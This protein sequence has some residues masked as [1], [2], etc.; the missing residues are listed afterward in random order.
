MNLRY[1]SKLPCFQGTVPQ[2]QASTFG[3]FVIEMNDQNLT[4]FLNL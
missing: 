2:N 1:L 3:C 4:R